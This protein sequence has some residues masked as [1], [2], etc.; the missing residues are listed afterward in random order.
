MGAD[1]LRSVAWPLLFAA[2]WALNAHV[3][4]VVLCYGGN[5]H[6]AVEAAHEGSCQS[7]ARRA[8]EAEPSSIPAS[9][10]KGCVSRHC[11]DVPLLSTQLGSVTLNGKS[12]TDCTRAF[13]R[14]MVTGNGMMPP[15]A[16]LSDSLRDIRRPS[17][18]HWVGMRSTVLV[19]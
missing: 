7:V 16:L 11:V 15:H 14:P 1:R 8:C 13:L 19:I 5:G 17:L 10:A 18:N 6:V 4:S 2:L 12:G 9:L 3:D